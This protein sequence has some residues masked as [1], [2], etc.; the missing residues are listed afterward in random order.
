MNIKV[1][2]IID[3]ENFEDLSLNRQ[4]EVKNKITDK[5]EQ[6]AIELIKKRLQEGFNKETI[7]NLLGIK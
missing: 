1:N 7:E 6:W 5:V 4:I 2:L 3:N